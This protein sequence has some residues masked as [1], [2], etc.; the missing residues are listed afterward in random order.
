[1]SKSPG[2]NK[3]AVNR[4]SGVSRTDQ[5]FRLASAAQI[6]GLAEAERRSEVCASLL[7]CVEALV[8]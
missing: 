7:D 1:M 3:A 4:S 2:A 6:P 8:S 5:I